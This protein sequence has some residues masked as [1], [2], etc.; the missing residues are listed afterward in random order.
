MGR[1]LY[2]M[3]KLAQMIN[4]ER[5]TSV[6][7]RSLEALSIQ[8]IHLFYVITRTESVNEPSA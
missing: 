8:A 7:K 4:F 1:F 3:I 6:N 5:S 2:L